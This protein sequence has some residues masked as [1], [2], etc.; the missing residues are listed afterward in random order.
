[1]KTKAKDLDIDFIGGEGSLS[2][3]EEKA[4]SEFFKSIKPVILQKQRS[5]TPTKKKKTKQ[6]A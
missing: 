5:T 1:M 6:L 2:E 3:T 4:L